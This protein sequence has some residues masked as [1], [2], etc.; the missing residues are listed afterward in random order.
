MHTKWSQY[1]QFSRRRSL[2]RGR[3][4][5]SSGGAER[6]SISIIEQTSVFNV[7]FSGRRISRIGLR[8]VSRRKTDHHT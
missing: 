5:R 6:Y 4:Y 3:H 7:L 8:L 2:W 1:W